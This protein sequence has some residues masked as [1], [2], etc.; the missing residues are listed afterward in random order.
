M[1]DL[2]NIRGTFAIDP[3]HST[4]SFVALHAM[5]TKVRGSFA[6]FSGTATGDASAP[7]DAKVNVEIQVASVDTRNNDRDQHLRTG[8]FFDAESY[9]TITFSS[10][11]VKVVDDESIEITGDLTIKDQTHPV[12]IPF[13]FT[14]AATDPFGNHRVG[15][16]GKTEINRKDWGLTWNA[17][18]ETGGI[19][20]SE[21][22]VMEF[23]VSL[24]EQA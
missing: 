1:S 3:T 20:V 18:L 4:I 22:I 24:I 2:H 8:D 7:E 15:F 13:E 6:E 5:I 21:K 11:S 23:D 9:P 17:A 12:T 10:T 14:G 16:E 19:L